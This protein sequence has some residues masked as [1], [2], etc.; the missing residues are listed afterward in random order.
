[1]RT[2]AI[3]ILLAVSMT[4]LV[5]QQNKPTFEVVSIKARL[6]GGRSG[7][8][9]QSG[10]TGTYT[11]RVTADTFYESSA[12]ISRLIQFAYEVSGPQLVGGPDWVREFPY[13]INAKAQGNTTIEQM[14]LMMQSLL[15]TR[16]K[17][18]ARVEQRDIMHEE[19]RVKRRDGR[20]G[21]SLQPCADPSNPPAF[22]PI[23]I[24]AGAYPIPLVGLCAPISKIVEYLSP[25]VKAPVVDKTGL[26]GFWN[27][28]L[29]FA[30]PSST[31]V[32]D[33]PSLRTALQEE[34][35]LLLQPAPGPIT[36][37]VIESIERPTEN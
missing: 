8:R 35:G 30:D 33:L 13:E 31:T 17:L 5:A 29:R 2:S 28:T 14:R 26:D 9:G 36:V 1:M 25:I 27:F 3:W 16:L 10:P 15:E 6:G 4:T 34:L 24:P 7:S 23:L 22:K 32:S 21:P 20:F 19:L 37:L 11:S 12:A 18:A